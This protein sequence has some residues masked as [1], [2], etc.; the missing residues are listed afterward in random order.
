MHGLLTD[1]MN[2]E[3]FPV[4]NRSNT[5]LLASAALI[6]ATLA[7]P[8][9]SAVET[10]GHQQVADAG[11][12]GTTAAINVVAPRSSTALGTVWFEFADGQHGSSLPFGGPR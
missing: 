10:A 4:T 8:A 6:L 1:R 7:A 11:N 9:F 2:P 12:T 5:V 3:G